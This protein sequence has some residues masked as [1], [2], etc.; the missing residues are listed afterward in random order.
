MEVMRAGARVTVDVRLSER[1]PSSTSSLD[2]R[3]TPF[4]P[5]ANPERR[6]QL[7]GLSV[8]TLD[9]SLSVQVS[10]RPG[11]RGVLVTR[12]PD[13]ADRPDML[14]LYDIIEEVGRQPVREPADLERL[15]SDSQG[16]LLLKVRRTENGESETR[17]VLWTNAA[18]QDAK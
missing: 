15:L 14:R 9:D 6:V 3:R 10:G 4:H 17:L 5:Q 2:H 7:S 13:H 1:K 12:C 16:S 18:A 11:V 8:V